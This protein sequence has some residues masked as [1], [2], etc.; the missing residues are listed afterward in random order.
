[1]VIVV[2]SDIVIVTSDIVIVIVIVII[3]VMGMVIASPTSFNDLLVRTN[4]EFYV[5]VI[6]AP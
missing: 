4:Y 5:I 6:V 3:M 1:L 2:T